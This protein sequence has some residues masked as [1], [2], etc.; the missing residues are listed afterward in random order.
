MPSCASCQFYIN[1]ECHRESPRRDFSFPKI[2]GTNYCGRF[3]PMR[4][5]PGS[6]DANQH[7]TRNSFDVEQFIPPASKPQ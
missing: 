4:F 7:R 6:D 3:E 1:G 5:E 2:E